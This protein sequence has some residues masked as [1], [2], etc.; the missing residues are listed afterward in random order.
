MP[1][2]KKTPKSSR[3][4]SKTAAS[5]PVS[6][7]APKPRRFKTPKYKTFRLSKQIKHP[8][9]LPS[10]WKLSKQAAKLLWQHRKLIIGITL[11]YGLL[12]IILVR[13]F[14]GS[15]DV[16][17]LKNVLNQIFDGNWGHFAS[18]LTIF[19]LLVTSAGNTTSSTGGTYQLLLVLI[20]SLA[21]IWT[22]RQV[23][24][25]HTKVRV[26][27]GFYRGMYPFIPF[28][29]VL[30]VIGVQLIPLLVG[31]T[32]YSTV[33]N[34][35]I[36][37]YAVEK[38]F[39]GLLFF[40]LALLSL[41]MI[42]SSIFALYIVTLPD[43]TPMKALRS[44][45]ELVRFRRWTVL[46]KVLFLPVALLIIAA[47]IMVPIITFA[48]PAAQWLFFILTMLA[49]AAVHAYMYTLYRELL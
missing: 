41:Y 9:A 29:L 38:F 32:L 36:A 24:A 1:A 37:V 6:K 34:N 17:E 44:A 2:S 18:S 25:G 13:G 47:I 43:M 48:T 16:S 31:S 42:C 26:R 27:D 45:R 28:V 20:I 23:L 12:N 39:W 3:K 7:I 10:A 15:T 35:G 22:F 14:S 8:Q 21:L 11:I 19:A 30:L 33:I 46:R 5:L 40:L 4:T 49:V